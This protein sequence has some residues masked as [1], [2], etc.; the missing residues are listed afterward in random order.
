LLCYSSDWKA[1]SD[2]HLH[3]DSI[4]VEQKETNKRNELF[5]VRNMTMLG[6]NT[7]DEFVC[8]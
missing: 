7:P 8:I 3:S 4:R 1:V 6:L 2:Q 5:L